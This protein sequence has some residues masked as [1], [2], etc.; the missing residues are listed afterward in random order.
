MES[1]AVAVADAV[2]ETYDWGAGEPIALIQTALTAD[3]LL[4]MATDPALDGYR[5]ILYHR[6]GYAGSSPQARSGSIVQEAAD[7]AGLLAEL[8]IARAHIVGL[9]FSGAIALQLAHDRPD[10]VHTVTLIEPPPVQTPSAEEFRSANDRLLE[11]R[12]TRGP[13]AALDEFL[14]TL[15]GPGWRDEIESQLPGSVRQMQAD[16]LTF[17]D[18]DLGS[19]MDWQFMADEAAELSCPALYVGGTDSGPWFHEVR[20][21]MLE[22][23]PQPTTSSSMA[24]TTPWPSRTPSSCRKRSL[25]SSPTTPSRSGRRRSGSNHR[26]GCARALRAKSKHVRASGHGLG[27]C[28]P[29]NTGHA[30]SSLPL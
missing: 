17:F 10:V 12:H 28:E 5:K 3:E 18:V 8:G 6:R 21:L 16:A 23:L 24:P 11:T 14:T 20:S 19:L 9:S 2:L 29:S 7:C 1:L 13:Q 15:V 4:P 30:S 27:G 26:R 25:V 22:W